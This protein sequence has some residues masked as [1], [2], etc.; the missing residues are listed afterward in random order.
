MKDLAQVTFDLINGVHVSSEK[1]S[2]SDRSTAV[3]NCKYRLPL[4]VKLRKTD[5]NNWNKYGTRPNISLHLQ[6]RFVVSKYYTSM[7]AVHN[8]P[9]HNQCRIQGGQF[10]VIPS[11][12]A[13]GPR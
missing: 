3:G 4:A 9:V 10:G 8:R 7:V 12:T 13:V 11:Q 1:I 2:T 6:R 5:F